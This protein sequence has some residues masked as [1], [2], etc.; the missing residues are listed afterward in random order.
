M[1]IEYV[2]SKEY[3]IIRRRI[4]NDNDL[5]QAFHSLTGCKTLTQRDVKDLRSL[6][7]NIIEAERYDVLDSDPGVATNYRKE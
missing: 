7:V 5:V 3:G 4:V 6:G 1:K 2:L